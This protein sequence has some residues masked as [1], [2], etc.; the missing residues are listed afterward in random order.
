MYID[1]YCLHKAEEIKA[2]ME[3]GLLSVTFPKISPEFA[4]KKIAIQGAEK[5]DWW[6][7]TP[8]FEKSNFFFFHHIFVVHLSSFL[9]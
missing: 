9:A 7:R 2:T 4:P 1:D 8:T 5:K 3:N 6:K